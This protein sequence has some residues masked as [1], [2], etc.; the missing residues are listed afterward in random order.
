M[1]Q[2]QQGKFVTTFVILT[3]VPAS[4]CDNDRMLIR[5]PT[6]V[7]VD[8]N[9]GCRSWAQG[10]TIQKR[11]CPL[12]KN[13]AKPPRQESLSYDLLRAT[14]HTVVIGLVHLL[15]HLE[16]V[17]THGRG[18]L[19]TGQQRRQSPTIIV[20][21]RHKYQTARTQTLSCDRTIMGE[22]KEVLPFTRLFALIE[23]TS[24]V[25]STCSTVTI[26]SK[27]SAGQVQQLK[28]LNSHLP[29]PLTPA[30]QRQKASLQNT[31]KSLKH[32]KQHWK[33]TL[34]HMSEGIY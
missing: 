34:D 30:P 32:G 31:L 11:P 28:P 3:K 18:H 25:Y 9:N 8:P 20:E 26:S 6:C 21:H 1:V 4:E 24:C 29:E 19:D 13:H 33:A 7:C 23:H 15:V 2:T 27:K 22:R 10:Y 14:A 12:G 16:K 5:I 17:C